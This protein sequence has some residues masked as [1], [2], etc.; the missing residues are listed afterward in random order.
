MKI[1]Y[2][3]AMDRDNL[4]YLLSRYD[5]LGG[6]MRVIDTSEEMRELAKSTF[7][8]F[9][10]NKRLIQLGEYTF[11]EIIED[12]LRRNAAYKR[13]DKVV[14]FESDEDMKV[15]IDTFE[16]DNPIKTSYNPTND[17]NAFFEMLTKI[18]QYG[19]EDKK[20]IDK[21]NQPKINKEDKEIKK[22]VNKRKNSKKTEE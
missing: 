8:K 6:F 1:S 9:N 7:S 17:I 15:M 12:I 3:E 10:H 19:V 22:K 18:S 11:D 14:N 4:L 2:K 13:E 21:Y 20:M 16:K 5:V